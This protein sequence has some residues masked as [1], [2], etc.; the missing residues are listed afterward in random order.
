MSSQDLNGV[1]PGPVPRPK[2][3]IRQVEYRKHTDSDPKQYSLSVEIPVPTEDE[4]DFPFDEMSTMSIRSI[5]G[6]VR[7]VHPVSASILAEMDKETERRVRVRE[8]K[9]EI[10]ETGARERS[11]KPSVRCVEVVS[12]R[13]ARFEG[14]MRAEKQKSGPSA[15]QSDPTEKEWPE[16]IDVV[17]RVTGLSLRT[18]RMGPIGKRNFL[19]GVPG[20]VTLHTPLLVYA[21][22][23]DRVLP[24]A[25]RPRD[26][27]YAQ[28]LMLATSPVKWD[29]VKG[30][31][32]LEETRARGVLHAYYVSAPLSAARQGMKGFG[33][34]C[35]LTPSVALRVIRLSRDGVGG[36]LRHMLRTM[37]TVNQISFP[38]LGICHTRAVGP[39]VIQTVEPKESRG[40]SGK[41]HGKRRV[42]PPKVRM[43]K[44]GRW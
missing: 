43:A 40:D 19:V 4:K 27:W 41:R 37:P 23:V 10:S 3:F 14:E 34:T 33:Q 44:R 25:L 20:A 36:A 29:R 11:E 16:A 28:L 6:F 17:S 1:K 15:E 22:P 38:A 30:E 7:P 24:P 31:I 9:E 2:T 26:W 18:E 12:R 32:T 35:P 13:L 5:G 21:Q 42:A 39:E 8:A